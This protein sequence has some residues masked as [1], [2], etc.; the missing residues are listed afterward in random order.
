MKK[1]GP[2]WTR[3]YIPYKREKC[4]FLTFQLQKVD[5][6]WKP[7]IHVCAA[8]VASTGHCLI[9]TESQQT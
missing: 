6:V 8:D 9:W 7:E 1:A 2:E 3:Q 5:M 4:P